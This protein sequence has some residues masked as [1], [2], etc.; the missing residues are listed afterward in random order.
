M[1]TSQLN[2]KGKK[3]RAEP[4]KMILIFD[5]SKLCTDICKTI[6]VIFEVQFHHEAGIVQSR[7]LELFFSEWSIF[8]SCKKSAL[9]ETGFKLF[10]TLAMILAKLAF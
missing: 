4:F 7:Y 9:N 6:F 3:G 5:A 1:N 8:S 10:R 2:Q